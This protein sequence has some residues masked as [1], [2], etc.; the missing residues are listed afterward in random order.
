[1]N[2]AASTLLAQKPA[3]NTASATSAKTLATLMLAAGVAATVVIADQLI[4]NWAETHL[5]AAWLAL[6]AVAALAQKLMNGLDAWSAEVAHRRAD[7]RLWNMAQSDTRLMRDL[8]VAMDR[9]DDDT[10]PVQDI[11]SYMTRR[12]ARMVRHHLHYI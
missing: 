4:D 9:A 2:T 7:Q 6:W 3:V 12:A 10:Q 1:M 8:Q 11:T 5:V